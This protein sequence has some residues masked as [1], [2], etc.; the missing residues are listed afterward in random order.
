MSWWDWNR[1]EKEIDWMALN[2]IN[3]PL[4]VT[5]EESIWQELYKSMGFTDKELDNFFTGPA[6]FSWLWMG[7]IDKWG[8]PL[9]KHWK[10]SHKI[11]E[12]KILNAERSF[13]MQPV[14]AAFT[15]HVPPSFK[16]RFPEA[17][18]KKTNWDAGFEDVYILDPSD[19]LFETIGKKF[20]ELQ[21]RV[22]GT[23]HFYSADTFNENVPP[24]DDSIYLSDISKKIFAS[25][26]GSDSLAVWVMQGWMF[27]Y[28]ASFWKS[29]QIQA[30]LNAV[31]DDHIILLDLYSESHPVWSRTS[32]YF[33][34]PWIWNMLHNFGGNISLWGRM[35]HAANDPAEALHSTSSGK[36]VGIGLTPEGI[37]QNPALYQLML[38][39]VW[40]DKPERLQEWLDQY[41]LQRYGRFNSTINKA[42]RLLAASVYRGDLGEGGPESIIVARPTLEKSIDR[43]LTKLDYDPAQLITAWDLFEK[44]APELKNSDG[45]Q[46]DLID[47]TRQVLANYASPLQQKWVKAYQQKDRATFKKYSERFL[48]LMDDMDRLLCARRDFLL[49]KWI[50]DARDNGISIEEKDLYEFNARDLITLWG[51]KESLLREYSNRQWAGLIKGFY[52]PRW[53]LFFS[54]LD[55]SIAKGESLN[56][57]KFEEEVKR[58]EWEWVH[59]HDEYTAEPKGNAILIV[60]EIYLKYYLLL[61]RVYK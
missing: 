41:A 39:N 37:E 14:L 30:I 50:R 54:Y 45:Y 42:W 26:T 32:A 58:W 4:A 49:G 27:H 19:P 61:K 6:Y 51:S 56:T 3:M 33:G 35:S 53:E 18:I 28:N 9:P 40:Q 20:I 34:K 25:M 15:G 7:N 13:G 17:K 10:D 21:T 59:M 29:G 12:I 22:Y 5:G 36:M 1:W 46:Y 31:P 47:L 55:I 23:D 38:D 60:R 48:I 43:V 2:G 24:T 16:K 52:K 57:A 11:L 8:G 44:A